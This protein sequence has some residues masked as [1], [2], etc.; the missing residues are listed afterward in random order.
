MIKR[1]GRWLEIHED[2][3]GLFL[4]TCLLL[5]LVRSSG[6]LLNNYA[7]T[8]FLK[9]FGV[10]YLPIVNMINAVAT[11]VVMALLTVLMTRVAS[12]RLFTYLFVFS[13]VSI[14]AIRLII[15]LGIDLIYPLLFML[16][17]QYEVLLAMFFWNLANDMFNTRQSKRLF[18]LI[19]AG[20]VIGQILSSF[21]TPFLARWLMLDNL[22][23]IYLGTTLC[24]A[25]VVASMGRRF[26]TLFHKDPAGGKKGKKRSMADQFK[27]VLP[28]IKKSVLIK[29]LVL[30]TFV[31][32]VLI[33]IMNYQFNYALDEQFATESGLIEF[34]GYFRG[35][36]NIVSLILLL[37]VKRLY[38]RWGLPV[39]LMF[40]PFNYVIIFTSFLLRFDIFTAIYARF[41]SNVLRTT[42]NIPSMAILNGLFPA[43]YRSMVRPFLRGTIVRV[44]LFMGHGM[45]LL[46]TNL[47]H[48][49]YLSL[50]A[51]PFALTWVGTTF[52][53]KRKYSQI[54]L[55]LITEDMIDL[56]SMKETD[57]SH[58]FNEP[59][60]KAHLT[61]AFAAAEG[62]KCLWHAQLLKLLKLPDLDL[63]IIAALE[64]QSDEKTRIGLVQ[65]LSP[66]A[67][68]T[69]VDAFSRMAP[70]AG[71]DLMTAMI[72]CANK[73]APGTGRAFNQ[74]VM[75]LNWPSEV[76]A[77][78][79]AGL[80]KAD[81][82]E[83]GA[84]ISGWLES[85]DGEQQKAGIIAAGQTG[86]INFASQL[87]S[88]LDQ[89]EQAAFIPLIIRGL[90][91]M[92][93][94]DLNHKV[95]RYLEHED[96]AVR[97]EAV[98]SWT[99][100]DDVDLD[101]MLHI[102]GNA[103]EDVHKAA[104]DAIVGA[105]YQNVQ[106][107]LEALSSP[108][109][110]KRAGILGIL[111][112][113]DIKDLDVVRFARSRTQQAYENLAA[114]ESL[115]LLP[116]G[117]ITTLLHD[118]L[119]QKARVDVEI[120]IKVLAAHDLT[121]RIRIL[122]RS[123]FYADKRQLD[124]S[125]E[126]LDSLLPQAVFQ[127]L[128]PLLENA[129]ATQPSRQIARKFFKIQDFGD[130]KLDL[131][132]YLISRGQWLEITLLIAALHNAPAGAVEQ[133]VVTKLTRAL[134]QVSGGHQLK[135]LHPYLQ[136]TNQK[137]IS[138]D[139]AIRLTDKILLVKEIDIF[140]DLSVSELAAVA[141]VTEAVS[142]PSNQ[143][144]IQEGDMGETMFLIVKGRVTVIKHLGAEN[145]LELDQIDSGD[146]FGEMAL[147]EDRQRSASI[148]TLTESEFL[149]L[150][151]AEF[152]EIVHEFPEIALNACRVLSDRIRRLHARFTSKD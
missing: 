13:G 49:K 113:M 149:V 78:A 10:E 95:A 12:V 137:E 138:M 104:H 105:D 133:S 21:A 145:E 26:P 97:L 7:E 150:H 144:V 53:L 73:Q 94:S 29:V 37:F 124:N 8:A 152:N 140:S 109:R 22:L 57:I 47:F 46:S 67:G 60:I 3:I 9:R 116:S 90:R 125:L 98:K 77:Y 146:Y 151:K 59:K 127:P 70:T 93:V 82:G 34:F 20:G 39:A 117:K 139:S 92:E 76:K 31:A 40:H 24:G 61:R 64:T 1:I 100:G 45:I 103:S 19:T 87:D 118:H 43:A 4:W 91:R 51:L 11:F 121:G 108:R 66:E 44:A 32:N 136:R 110:T 36:L 86:A 42:V 6:I 58:L 114:A 142:H 69:A 30:L 79:A 123:L 119:K 141:S 129:T 85:A 41:S 15:P 23:F 65:L 88:L 81:M 5:F 147:F 72:R 56:K 106:L 54:L 16:K 130:N 115:D 102:I 148:R 132:D 107:L 74:Q 75:H 55:D 18:P 83:Y 84:I 99:I 2:E 52:F 112:S 17:S 80:Y 71:P 126:A 143:V 62:E 28:L 63:K 38:S 96:T 68:Q 135:H 111:E 33:P 27:D 48:P 50:V 89:P 120:V 25:V 14:A 101:Q 122:T 128:L 35:V 131:V 134:Q